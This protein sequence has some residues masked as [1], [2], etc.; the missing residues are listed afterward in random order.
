[1]TRRR[2]DLDVDDTLHATR[3]HL[4]KADA[5]ITAAEGM[6][7]ERGAGI[8]DTDEDRERDRENY[9]YGGDDEI[10]RRRNHLEEFIESA[11]LAVRAAQYAHNQTIAKLD[12]YRAES[13]QV[14]TVEVAT[15]IVK[16][17]GKA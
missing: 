15:A 13:A 6:I 1:V 12:R 16:R 4:W 5:F 10:G 7:V 14:D 8:E 11:K 2:D 9:G 17:R 3:D